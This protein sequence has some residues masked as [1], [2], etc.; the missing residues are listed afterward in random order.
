[1]SAAA[2]AARLDDLASRFGLSPV[3]RAQLGILLELLEDEQAPTTV[4][5]PGRA[6]EA[7]IAD[8]LTGLE[9]EQVR[10]ARTIADLGAGAGIPGLVLAAALPE[11][12]VSLV[13]SVGKKAAYI[14]RVAAA[15]GLDN[16][17]VVASRAES[18]REGIGR[19]DV[20]T[21][22]AV[23]ALPILVEYAA[24][25]LSAGGALVAWKSQPDP[26]EH[27]DGEHAARILGMSPARPTPIAPQPGADRRSLY[28]YVKLRETPG[29]YPRRPGIARKRPLRAPS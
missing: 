23:A 8:A 26:A 7:H 4:H 14:D 6:V 16:A 20:V 3:A 29:I 22:R 11:A 28:V 9:V 21:A 17:E 15:M 18:W 1:V 10:T 5:E 13:E 19:C 27:E 24:P 2:V 12:H 25:L